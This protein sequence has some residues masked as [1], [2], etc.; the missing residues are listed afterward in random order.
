MVF[1]VQP[2]WYASV[3]YNVSVHVK[4]QKDAESHHCIMLFDQG[5]IST[6][7]A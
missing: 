2:R 6:S 3:C 4:R 5:S 7:Q 1:I